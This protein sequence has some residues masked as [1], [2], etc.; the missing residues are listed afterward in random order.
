MLDTFP[1]TLQAGFPDQK[2]QLVQ[3]VRALSQSLV[4]KASGL[5]SMSFLAVSREDQPALPLLPK[6]LLYVRLVPRCTMPAVHRKDQN[7]ALRPLVF[8]GELDW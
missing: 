5:V 3:S 2:R 1:L 8:S 4:D 7:E 6:T